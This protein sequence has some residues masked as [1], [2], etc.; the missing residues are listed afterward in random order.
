MADEVE[1][2]IICDKCDSEY[3]VMYV[4]ENVTSPPEYCP[5][6]GVEPDNKDDVDPEF[7]GFERIVK[8]DDSSD[9][10]WDDEDED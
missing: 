5:F 3:T 9:E 6:C 1:V 4:N 10:E 7:D 2:K 8:G